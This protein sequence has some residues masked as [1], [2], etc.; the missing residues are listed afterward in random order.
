MDIS[1]PVGDVDGV[2]FVFVIVEDVGLGVGE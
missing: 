2:G 1:V